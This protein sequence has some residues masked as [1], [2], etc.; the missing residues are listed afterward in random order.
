MG[1]GPREPSQAKPG[2]V[3]HVAHSTPRFQGNRL[4]RTLAS[5]NL[6]CLLTRFSC[7]VCQRHFLTSLS[8]SPHLSH[9]QSPM[10]PTKETDSW[11]IKKS[12]EG[13]QQTLNAC[14]A[15][16]NTLQS[17]RRAVRYYIT[18]HH[19]SSTVTSYLAALVSI[20]RRS[21]RRLGPLVYVQPTMHQLQSA[22][23]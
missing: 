15:I 21:R 16:V 5:S 10:F 19:P 11:V 12:H 7:T 3:S 13:I 2:E 23:R 4:E 17:A 20:H 1:I 14:V 9:L 22:A 18:L 6:L 8:I